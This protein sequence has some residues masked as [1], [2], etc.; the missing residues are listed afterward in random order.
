MK[1]PS[2]QKGEVSMKRFR[3]LAV[4]GALALCTATVVWGDYN[5]LDKGTYYQNATSGLRTNSTGDVR[6]Q[7]QSPAMDANLTFSN[8][9][10][11]TTIAVGSA[12]SSAILDTHRMR[13]GMLLIKAVPV[14]GGTG[15]INRLAVQIRVHL[16]GA[17]DTSSVFAVYQYGST[18]VA[19]A[20]AKPD[21]INFGHL[22]TGS[23]TTQYSGEFMVT[24]DR[25][26]AQTNT[27]GGANDFRSPQG[28]AIPLQSLFGRDL[29][30]PY[31]SVRIRNIVGPS[32][33]VTAHLVGTPL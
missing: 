27:G 14:G 17:S 5:V 11:A 16:N 25:V 10:G 19:T 1:A 31:V 21:T 22:V 6:T 28:I 9:I 20:D 2:A 29:Y 33:V 26:R 24:S 18:Q 4:L 13:L 3:L 8:I 12:D 23:T 7:E 32:C 15:L 30:A